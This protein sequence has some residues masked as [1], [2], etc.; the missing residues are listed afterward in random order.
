VKHL[1]SGKFWE[2]YNKL[3]PEVKQLADANFTLLK[4]DERHPSLQ[5]KKVGRFLSVRVGR[6]HRALAVQSKQGLVWFWIGSHSE[7]D[8]LIT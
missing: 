1:A 2:A 7:Y 5:L 4:Q 8:R 3:H 6:S